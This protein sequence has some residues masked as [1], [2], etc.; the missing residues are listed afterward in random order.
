ME[1]YRGN[2]H[3]LS[4]VTSMVGGVLVRTSG[5]RVGLG[6]SEFFFGY[7]VSISFPVEFMFGVDYVHISRA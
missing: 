6:V 7:L 1:Q 2:D 3:F 5:F 4:E